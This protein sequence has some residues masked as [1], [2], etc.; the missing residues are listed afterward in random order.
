MLRL[1]VSALI[2]ATRV[3]WND[4]EFLEILGFSESIKLIIFNTVFD[5]EPN[6]TS[7]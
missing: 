5:A 7:V 4:L 3:D 6:S 1:A 2:Q